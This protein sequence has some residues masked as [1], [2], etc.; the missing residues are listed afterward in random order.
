M[1]RRQLA[2]EL[3][4][5][6]AAAGMTVADV[7][8]AMGC[9]RGKVSHLESGRNPPSR[10]DL[11]LMLHLY[12]AVDR[13]DELDELRVAGNAPGWWDTYRLPLWMK[14]YVGLETDATAVRCF[15]L[16]LI[17]GLLQNE[18]YAKETFLRQGARPDEVTQMVSVRMERQ[19]RLGKQKLEVVASE[20][21]LARTVHM[22]AYGVDQL[23]WIAQANRLRGVEFLVLPFSAGGHRS[24]S[25]SFTLLE[26]PGGSSPVAY[27]DYAVGG[28]LVDDPEVVQTLGELYV[29]LREQ[30][31][32]VEDSVEL[33][34]RYASDGDQTREGE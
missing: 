14:A 16:E 21:L 17:P 6:R 32:T 30:A 25:G 33:I 27:Q 4:Q 3:R 8:T 19:R 24:M 26:F 20:A 7:A 29:D 10:P 31:L 5:L 9:V 22:G 11:W 28:H 34:G 12:G 18:D 13:L 15:A 1:R 2:S 23:R